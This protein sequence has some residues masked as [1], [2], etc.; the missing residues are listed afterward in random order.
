MGA[1]VYASPR[2]KL[3]SRRKGLWRKGQGQNRTREIRPSGIVGGLA[4]TWT[5]ERA[6]RAR[7]AETPKQ[8]SLHLRPRAPRFYPDQVMIL[9]ICLAE[10]PGVTLIFKFK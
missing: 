2:L 8:P 1:R 3:R 5:M 4:E 7:K 10:T 6:K 9:P